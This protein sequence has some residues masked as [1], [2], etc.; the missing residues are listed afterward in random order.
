MADGVGGGTVGVPSVFGV[1][2]AGDAAPAA[3][4]P[5]VEAERGSSAVGTDVGKIEKALQET[6]SKAKN[7]MHKARISLNGP[8]R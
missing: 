6:G 3:V 7:P 1:V 5:V 2:A 4:P 8:E